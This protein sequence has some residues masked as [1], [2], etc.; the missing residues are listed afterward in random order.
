MLAIG[1][2]LA[3][4]LADPRTKQD[5]ASKR[6]TE[7][8]DPSVQ[9]KL[10]RIAVGTAARSTFGLVAAEFLSNLE[11]NGAAP[12]TLAKNKWLLEDL[13]V[14]LANRPFAEITAAEILEL[15]KRIEKTGRREASRPPRGVIG[16][17]FRL[18]VVT[19][20]AKGDST[21]ALQDVL[22]WASTKPRPAITDE[23][24]FGGAA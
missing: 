24:Q 6:L 10:R 15:S 16:A 19:L 11:A 8:A 2:F 13:A 14:T 9:K 1:P 21:S 12:A 18:A 23:K 17:V 22:L 5:E 20:R 3:I 4:S 7:G